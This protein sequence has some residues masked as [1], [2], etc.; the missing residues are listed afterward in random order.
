M[1]KTMIAVSVI[2]SS[3]F[4][5]SLG[6]AFSLGGLTSMV[7]GGQANGGENLSTAQTQTVADYAAGSRLV[8][9]ANIKMAQALHLDGQVAELK[10]TADAIQNGATDASLKKGDD[11]LSASTNAIVHQ[12][13]SN[14]SMDKASKATFASGLASLAMGSVAYAKTGKDLAASQSALSSASPAEMMR[15]GQLLYIAK[16]FPGNARN[17]L[18]SLRVGIQYAKGQDIPVPANAAD[19]TA[20][21]A[22]LR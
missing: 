16:N 22:D 12:L 2:A 8:L 18:N 11:T 14:P 5:P 6:Q 20:A 13:K 4:V 10:A 19:A 17:F 7:S 15:L 3:M 21:L 9:N 1:K